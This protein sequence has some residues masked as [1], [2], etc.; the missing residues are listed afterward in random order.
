MLLQ[1]YFYWFLT[2]GNI[3]DLITVDF[4][5]EHFEQKISLLEAGLV[6]GLAG[7]GSSVGLPDVSDGQH[8]ASALQLAE[9]VLL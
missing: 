7:E 3:A 6:G 2:F 1:E 8:A 4:L 9:N 5:T